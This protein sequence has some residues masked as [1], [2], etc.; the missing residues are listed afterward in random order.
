MASLIMISLEQ[1]ILNQ[2]MRDYVG[3]SFEQYKKNTVDTFIEEMRSRLDVERIEQ[4][5]L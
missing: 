5:V 4:S 1:S 3:Y 2:S